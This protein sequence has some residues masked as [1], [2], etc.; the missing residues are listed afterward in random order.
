L[1]D[2]LK[3][4]VLER[5]GDLI[6]FHPRILEFA[7][8][9]HFAPK[10][11]AVARGNEKPRVER[12]IRYLRESFFAARSFDSLADLNRQLDTWIAQVA[13]QRLVPGESKQLVGHALEQERERLLPLPEHPFSALH[14]R[15]IRSG[16]TPYV[17]FDKNDYSIPHT[18]VRKPLTLVTSDTVVRVL[19][20][21]IEVAR[22]PR[23]W[24]QGQQVE[25][26]AHL[27][28]LSAEK[29]KAREHRGRNRLFVAC[30][31][32]TEFLAEVA[33]HDGHLGGTTSRLL[34]L[35]DQYGPTEL[36]AALRDAHQRS[37]FS[38][39]S[40][41]HV[42]DQRR[43]ARGAT[44]PLDVPL[45]HDPRVRDLTVTPHSLE[46]YDR[47]VQAGGATDTEEA[48]HD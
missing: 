11:V 9:Y 39:Q 7:G 13:H 43:R 21:E 3:S 37:A 10:P 34:R 22:H 12:R 45:S 42:L 44:I 33:R 24:D 25:C 36:D 17:R 30:P 4:V 5:Q 14:L 27:E 32:A 2:N 38:A 29:R 26:E 35:L 40:V 16:K 23:S 8:Y 46:R 18:L 31:A 47:L 15:A 20:G 19:D 1:Y 41:A 48:R 6:R 28:A